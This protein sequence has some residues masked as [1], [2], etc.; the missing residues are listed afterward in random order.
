MYGV[1]KNPEFA[2]SSLTF[3]SMIETLSA[4]D[5]DC[6]S[7]IDLEE[8]VTDSVS[9]EGISLGG[10]GVSSEP[11]KPSG[12]GGG[13]GTAMTEVS[14]NA[15]TTNKKTIFINITSINN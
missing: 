13:G 11:P 8:S 15:N 12:A 14:I 3:F 2:S 7:S 5:P 10:G 4:R 6:C 9:N 1:D